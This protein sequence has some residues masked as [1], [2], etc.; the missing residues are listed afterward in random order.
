MDLNIVV[1]KN[2]VK[3]TINTVVKPQSVNRKCRK[4]YTT[5]IKVLI[6]GFVSPNGNYGNLTI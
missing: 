3:F 1:K 6:G 2:M 5:V 4:K